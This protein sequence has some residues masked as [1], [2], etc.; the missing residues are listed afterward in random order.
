M[1]PRI[2]VDSAASVDAPLQMLAA[3]HQHLA[4]QCDAL[5]RL[6]AHIAARSAEEEAQQAAQRIV[7]AF[8]SARRDHMEDE[9]LDLFPALIESMAGSDAVCLR[10]LTQGLAHEHDLIDAAW[11]PLSAALERIAAGEAVALPAG[12]VED[13]VALYRRHLERE[14]AELLPMAARL[15]TDADIARLSRAMRER[16]SIKP[17]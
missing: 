7:R 5:L 2:G 1:T 11:R 4:L 16:R 10:E 15:L 17:L 9:E 8:N 12:A 6:V 3:G 13:F 14:D